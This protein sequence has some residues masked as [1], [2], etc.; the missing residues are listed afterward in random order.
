MTA[1][2]YILDASV[3]AKWYLDDEEHVE[4]AE[5]FLVRMLSDEIELHA[6]V[7]LQYEM[8]HL[9]T[10]AQRRERGRIFPDI[11]YKAF[12]NFYR[13]PIIFH[14]LDNESMCEAFQMAQMLNRS[15]YDTVFSGWR[16]D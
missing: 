10:K 8:G 3:A 9:L 4:K 14:D 2:K 16:S 12:K 5:S 11:A 15:F 6:P 1:Q 7:L 13:L